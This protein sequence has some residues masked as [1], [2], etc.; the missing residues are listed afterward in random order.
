[1]LIAGAEPARKPV[2]T[3]FTP[4]QA[5]LLRNQTWRKLQLAYGL[6]PESPAF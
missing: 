5:A 6:Q 3:G 4:K 2:S 1:M